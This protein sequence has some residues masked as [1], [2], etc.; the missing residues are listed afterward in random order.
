[1]LSKLVINEQIPSQ[2]YLHR[3]SFELLNVSVWRFL[4]KSG[5]GLP[6]CPSPLLSGKNYHNIL[7]AYAYLWNLRGNIGRKT[8]LISTDTA[9]IIKPGK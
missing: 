2:G 4:I 8:L 9:G 3:P 5:F 6:S 7:N 1:M